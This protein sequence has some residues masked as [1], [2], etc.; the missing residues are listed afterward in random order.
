MPESASAATRGTGLLE[1][2]EKPFDEFGV[3]AS[4]EPRVL[5][6]K[7]GNHKVHCTRSAG[8][9]LH[10]MPTFDGCEKVLPDNVSNAANATSSSPLMLYP[11]NL[12]SRVFL[13]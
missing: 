6:A 12:F 5:V 2:R 7:H 1:R 9:L 8:V 3:E 4:G 11:V 10:M 13:K